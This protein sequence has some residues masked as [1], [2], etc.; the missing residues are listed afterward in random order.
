[1]FWQRNFSTFLISLLILAQSN[2]TMANDQEKKELVIESIK[3]K[4]ISNDLKGN[5]LLEGNVFIKTNLLDFQTDKAFFNES[6]GQL[7]LN[8]NV[9]VTRLG[10]NIASSEIMAN[11]KKQSFSIKNTEINRADTSFIK[12][13][14]F[15]IKT[16]G[17]VELINSSVNNCSKDDPP[18]EISIKR[19]DYIEKQKNDKNWDYFLKFRPYV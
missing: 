5:L 10:L 16:S 12:A 3:A 14:L 19:I 18:W 15:H 2:L 8:G 13:E 11:L 1:M 9:E 6:N 4:K 7:E 17:D